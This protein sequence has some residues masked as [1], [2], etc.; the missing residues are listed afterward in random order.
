MTDLGDI[1][2]VDCVYAAHTIEHLYPHEVQKAFA[3]FLRVLRPGGAFVMLVPDLENVR[4]TD[5]VVYI[6]T[7]GP[8]TGF[9]MYYGKR[10]LLDEQP[11]M[12]H[13]CGFV[14]DTL[15]KEL[16]AAGFSK[17]KVDAYGSLN[18]CGVGLK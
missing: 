6:S 18:L 16:E 3:E 5:E 7:A 14:R 11:Y 10:D 17:V 15:T 12:A 4:P 13:H 1:G 8:I 9:D 2:P